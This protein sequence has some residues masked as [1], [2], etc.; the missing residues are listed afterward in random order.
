MKK[1]PNEI[2]VVWDE[3]DAAHPFLVP[4]TDPGDHLCVGDTRRVGVYALAGHVVATNKT[5][6]ERVPLKKR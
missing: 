1:L 2:F 6:V 3:S 4:A 5:T